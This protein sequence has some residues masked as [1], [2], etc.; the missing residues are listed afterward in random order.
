MQVQLQFLIVDVAIFE[1][2]FQ[3]LLIT[4][5]SLGKMPLSIENPTRMP[6][7]KAKA[8]NAINFTKQL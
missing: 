8:I 1:G 4:V 5:S 2:V 6:V 7:H 3:H